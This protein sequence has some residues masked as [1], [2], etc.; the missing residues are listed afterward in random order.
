[1]REPKVKRAAPMVTA[2]TQASTRRA[3]EAA[4]RSG[5]LYDVMAPL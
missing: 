3:H 4:G 2:M 5:R 1:M